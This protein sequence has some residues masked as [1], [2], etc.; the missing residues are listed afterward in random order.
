MADV[1]NLYEY[2]LAKKISKDIP[3][4]IDLLEKMDKIL[5]QYQQYQAAADVRFTI[6]D[7]LTD[8]EIALHRYKDV[9]NRKGKWNETT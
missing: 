6:N 5:S 7:A 1:F 2:T 3:K 8:L 9:L 4:L